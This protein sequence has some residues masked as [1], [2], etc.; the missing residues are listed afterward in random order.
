[1]R[2]N[3]YTESYDTDSNLER[4][5]EVFLKNPL[6]LLLVHID[7]QAIINVLQQALQNIQKAQC[8][9]NAYYDAAHNI[10]R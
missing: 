9:Q 3:S 5:I 1:M 7:M 2:P 4:N 8:R 6:M 10:D